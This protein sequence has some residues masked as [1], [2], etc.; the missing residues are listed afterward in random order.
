MA[1]RP[2]QEFPA[3]PLAAF[4]RSQPY[5]I[6]AQAA[7]AM[8]LS[9]QAVITNW[10][11]RDRIPGNMLLV[12]A[13]YL[14]MTIDQYLEA[15]GVIPR[16]ADD[17]DLPLPHANEM[18]TLEALGSLWTRIPGTIQRAFLAIAET[19]AGLS[20]DEAGK[21]LRRLGIKPRAER[22][23]RPAKNGLAGKIKALK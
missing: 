3:K 4:F 7:R 16:R 11:E 9:S 15:A 2:R 22:P 8:G 12:V 23:P 1:E 18:M 20:E 13:N 19:V 14:G 5:G 21:V 10:L 6:K 17:A